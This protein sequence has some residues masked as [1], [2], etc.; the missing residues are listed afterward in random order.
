MAFF[1]TFGASPE[2]ASYIMQQLIVKKPLAV[3]EVQDRQIDHNEHL[4]K[5]KRFVNEI[6]SKSF[7]IL[8]NRFSKSFWLGFD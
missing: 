8:S 3:L 5:I 6:K 1:T 2:N 4:E 7:R